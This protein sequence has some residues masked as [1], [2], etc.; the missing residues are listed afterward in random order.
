MSTSENESSINNDNKNKALAAYSGI[1]M[2]GGGEEAGVQ[3]HNVGETQYAI[4]PKPEGKQPGHSIIN[5]VRP[6]RKSSAA[7][8]EEAEARFESLVQMYMQRLQG[9]SNDGSMGSVLAKIEEDLSPAAMT[10]VISDAK[11][12]IA[13]QQTQEQEQEEIDRHRKYRERLQQ[14][15]DHCDDC[16]TTLGYLP[17]ALEEHQKTCDQYLKRLRRE[18]DERTRRQSI[19]GQFERIEKSISTISSDCRALRENLS[20]FKFVDAEAHSGSKDNVVSDA[21]ESIRKQIQGESEYDKGR[22][23]WKTANLR[24]LADSLDAFY[25]WFEGTQ[26]NKE[27]S[28]VTK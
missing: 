11:R 20:N 21:L 14:Y 3:I 10:Q 16:N 9:T 17:G 5:I 24:A 25:A 13:A 4:R 19:I 7:R 1:S 2:L 23:R 27:S 15:R 22:R 28:S 6:D 18:E 8:R 26:P 12:R